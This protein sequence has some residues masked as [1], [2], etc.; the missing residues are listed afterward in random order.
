MPMNAAA[1]RDPSARGWVRLSILIAALLLVAA[2]VLS[3]S[4]LA[5]TA[6]GQAE[7]GAI[8][9]VAL[10]SNEPG[11]LVITWQA[12][13]PAPT[14]YRIRWAN[15]SM[16][17]PSYNAPNEPERGN[18][19][20]AGDANTLTLNDLT[21]GENYKVQ[22]RARYYNADR[23]VHERSG[24]WTATAT[25]RV[26][27][28]PPAAPTGL[29][30][31]QVAHD[32]LTLTWND[33]QDA[34]IT[35]YRV[36]RGSDAGSLST[37][38]ADTES[39]GAEYTDSTVTAETTY[40]YA[41]MA[42]SADGDSTQSGTISVTTPAAPPPADPPPADPSGLTAARVGHSVLTLT[43]DDPQDARITT[44]TASCEDPM[45]AVCPPSNPASLLMALASSPRLRM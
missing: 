7:S 30:A 29:T 26:K 27:D 41:V 20:P 25:Q 36:L 10:D 4:G 17:F 12:P 44:G 3:V 40:H 19:H 18:S 24:P 1:R 35:G 23:T 34:D 22:I 45:P 8:P 21:P 43:W 11:Q 13:D 38:E 32:S 15:A 31:S 2:M 28:H 33:P 37:I 42:L 9:S 6:Q 14:D 16:G 5:G 39:A